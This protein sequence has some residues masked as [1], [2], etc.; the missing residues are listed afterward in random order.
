MTPST[1]DTYDRTTQRN[2]S[3]TQGTR[4][5]ALVLMVLALVAAT[6]AIAGPFARSAAVV[7]G[8]VVDPA[9][10]WAAAVVGPESSCS[11]ALVSPNVVLSLKHCEAPSGTVVIVGHS[12]P[13][14]SPADARIG[15]ARRIDNPQEDLAAF[16]LDRS[17][18][19]APIPLGSDDPLSA[20]MSFIP[21]TVYGYGRAN[22]VNEPKPILDWRL[23]SAVGE[24]TRC[25]P[26]YDVSRFEYCLKPQKIS[27][28]CHGDSGGPLV[29]SGHLMGLFTM[30]IG[31]ADP[32]VCVG[33]DW[34][35][36]SVPNSE[37]KQ[38][39]NDTIAANPPSS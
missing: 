21:F 2:R 35:A 10:S 33:A 4:R 28:P 34:V 8:P 6:V 18:T 1:S 17:V 25:N 7:N 13:R 32:L 36:I 20:Q 12:D 26:R 23:R 22:D 39:V 9:P 3:S 30:Y 19:L 15:I 27:A 5:R 31:E 38:W 16:V 14:N 29:A 37:I 24:V 11:G